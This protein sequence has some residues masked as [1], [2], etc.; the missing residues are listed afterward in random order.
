MFATYD[1]GVAW[2][3]TP[4]LQL[5][6]AELIS[7]NREHDLRQLT[8]GNPARWLDKL[9]LPVDINGNHGSGSFGA[10]LFHQGLANAIARASHNHNFIREL[11][12]HRED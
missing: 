5:R 4:G 6:M 11:S 8:S 7:A 2:S 3:Q 9:A 1:N 10:K 12:I